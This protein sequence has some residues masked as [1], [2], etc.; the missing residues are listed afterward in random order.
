MYGKLNKQLSKKETWKISLLNWVWNQAFCD[1]GAMLLTFE[2]SSQ[3]GTDHFVSLYSNV[4]DD[5][6][7][8]V[9]LLLHY[10]FNFI[11]ILR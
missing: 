4:D 5:M 7:F 3:L 2:L 8:N 11:V 9:M 1:T 6:K 10:L